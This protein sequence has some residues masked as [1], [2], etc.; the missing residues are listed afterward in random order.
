MAN[1]RLGLVY[2]APYSGRFPPAMELPGHEFIRAPRPQQQQETLQSCCR[3]G[4]DVDHSQPRHLPYYQMNFFLFIDSRTRDLVC[5]YVIGIMI[6]CAWADTVAIFISS[7]GLAA[8]SNKKLPPCFW[9]TTTYD[10][11]RPRGVTENTRST[12][13]IQQS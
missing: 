7:K 3:A 1:H 9:Q 4:N 2:Q 13:L 5:S 11:P 6:L 10:C 8:L 12:V